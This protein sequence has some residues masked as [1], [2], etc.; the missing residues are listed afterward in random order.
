[1]S[2][3]DAL[4]LR[5]IHPIARYSLQALAG[6]LG[7]IVGIGL[8]ATVED[9]FKSLRKFMGR[10]S[11]DEIEQEISRDKEGEQEWG[12]DD[13][14]E[15]EDEE[16]QDGGPLPGGSSTR[17][18]VRGQTMAVN[19]F[20]GARRIVQIIAVLWVVVV[21]AFAFMNWPGV[22]LKYVVEGL[23]YVPIRM[24]DG[25]ECSLDDAEESRYV[26]VAKRTDVRLSLCFKGHTS[27]TGETGMIPYRMAT[28]IEEAALLEDRFEKDIRPRINP[29]LVLETKEAYLRENA[30]TIWYMAKEDNPEVSAHTRRVTKQFTLTKEDERWAYSE[31]WKELFTYIGTALAIIAG[32]W[33]VLW[34]VTWVIGYIVRGFLGIPMGQDRR[35]EKG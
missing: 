1:M 30:G 11:L 28:D 12:D 3:A 29:K 22:T 8:G 23:D 31:W 26:T 4:L 33:T 21:S 14:D 34:V 19:I 6:I 10:K 5:E 27:D 16:E 17:P 24:K 9:G 15:E 18:A 35:V 25:E 7:L 20:E 32:G 13:E 2:L